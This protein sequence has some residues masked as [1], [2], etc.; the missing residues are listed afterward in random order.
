VTTDLFERYAS[1]D[2]AR[3]PGIQPAW[4]PVSA[5]LLSTVD[6]REPTMQTQQSPPTQPPTKRN[7]KRARLLIGA[8][9]IGLVLIVGAVVLLSNSGESELPP[10]AAPSTT[11]TPD[12]AVE[13]I[14]TPSEADA[15]ANAW[16]DAFNAGDIDAVMA[17]FAPDPILS[18]NFGGFTTLEEERLN[19]IWNAAQG[20]SLDTD[21]CVPAGEGTQRRHV[22][23]VGTHHDALVHAV[24]ATPVPAIVTMTIGPDGIVALV[25]TYGSPDFKTD[26]NQVGDPFDMWMAVHHPE[27]EDLS[28]GSFE[29]A[30]EAEMSGMLT[31]QYAAEWATYLETNGCTY[32]DGC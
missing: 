6:G 13:S 8:A 22:R 26:F 20:T 12:V 4:R 21:G 9:A 5:V 15:V 3:A 2:P 32:L 10:A 28:F 14:P 31:A 16:Y 30:K 11:V 19:N 1:L 23:C 17:L 25:Y 18:S 29:T 27:V 24:D 7:P